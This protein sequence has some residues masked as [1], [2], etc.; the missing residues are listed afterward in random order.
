[1][2]A[3]ANLASFTSEGEGWAGLT[4]PRL[5]RTKE[6]CPLLGTSRFF[7]GKLRLPLTLRLYA[8]GQLRLPLVSL[9]GC[10]CSM[11]LPQTVTAC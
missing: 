9:A 3:C 1:M 10:G 2:R 8:K 7:K 11:A 4:K 5:S 6:E